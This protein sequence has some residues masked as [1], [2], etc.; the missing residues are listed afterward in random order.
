LKMIRFWFYNNGIITAHSLRSLGS[1]RTPSL[2]ILLFSADPASGV[3]GKR[4]LS[5]LCALCASAVKN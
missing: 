3:S 5:F 4:K 1:Q 2:F